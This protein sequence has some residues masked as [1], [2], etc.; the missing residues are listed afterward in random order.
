VACHQR[1][2]VSE[3]LFAVITGGGTGGHVSPAL[4]VAEALVDRGHAR[5]EIEFVAGR[6][7][8]EERLVPEAGFVLHRLP[9]RGIKRRLTME[10]VPAALGLLTSVFIS[11]GLALRRRPRVVVTV[12]GYAGF[13]YAMAA[14]L[15]RIPL[16]AVTN[17]AIPGAVNRLVGR[18]ASA[19]AVAYPETELPNATVTGPPVRR[20]VLEV[21]RDDEMRSKVGAALGLVPGSRL[22]VV[23]GG[24]LGAGSVNAAAIDLASMWADRDDIA[25]YHVA[26][27]RNLDAVRAS[28]GSRGLLDLPAPGLQYRLVGYDTDLVS[29]LGASD[30]AICRA[31]ASTIAELTAIGVPSVLVPLPGAPGDHQTKNAQALEKAGAALMIADN[32]CTGESLASAVT[33]CLSDDERLAAMSA[34]ARSLGHRDA[35]DR[36]AALADHLA[37]GRPTRSDR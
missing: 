3:P 16:V 21:S 29:A 35:A 15:C 13:P 14:I 25:I 1:Y 37:L 27:D 7:G 36:V 2:V 31:G 6:R 12:G 4:A 33:E 9:G 19:N 32:L 18:F 26:G 10:N 23:T 22:I 24:S 30:L 34:A 17:D 5:S 20:A 8:I 11:I 28:A